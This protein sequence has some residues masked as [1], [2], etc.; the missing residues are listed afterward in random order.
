VPDYRRAYVPGGTFFLTFVTFE[1]QRL[2]AEPYDIARLR[3]AIAAVKRERPFEIIAAAVM[4]DHIHFVWTLPPGDA[5]F[6]SRAGRFKALFTRSLTASRTLEAATTRSRQRHRESN[7][8]QRRFWEHV[9]RDERDLERHLDYIHYNPVKHG[10]V[11]CP[12]LWPHSS[13]MRWVRQ[14]AYAANWCC[15]CAVPRGSVPD[16][17]DIVDTI[18]E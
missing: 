6:S 14:G 10:L 1:R 13:F 4:P 5:D 18:G 12:H 2:L 7:V 16:F 3:R 11:S 17:S 9:V 15:G 8:W